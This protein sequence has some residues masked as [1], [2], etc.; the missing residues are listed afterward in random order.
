MAWR[1]F[2][3]TKDSE[4]FFFFFTRDKPPYVTLEAL[5][6][7]SIRLGLPGEAPQPGPSSLPLWVRYPDF[8]LTDLSADDFARLTP[9]GATRKDTA[10]LRVG[11]KEDRILAVRFAKTTQILYNTD[12]VT[13]RV[14]NGPYS[15]QPFLD[16][17][18]AIRGWSDRGSPAG[19]DVE[20]GSSDQGMVVHGILNK[21]IEGY[22]ACRSELAK[23][24]LTSV[25]S[26]EGDIYHIGEYRADLELKLK[27]D[28]SL[29]EKADEERFRLQLRLRVQGLDQPAAELVLAPAGL[30]ISGPLYDSFFDNLTGFDGST[31]L[32]AR[33]GTLI[34]ESSW[35]AR[36]LRAQEFARSA[37]KDS[38]ILLAG[39]GLDAPLYL[40]LMR[41]SLYDAPVTL[42]WVAEFSTKSQAEVSWNLEGQ[43]ETLAGFAGDSGNITIEREAAD[44]IFPIIKNI[45]R[46]GEFL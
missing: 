28:G 13:A 30:L 39:S 22:L 5:V 46:W 1:L 20:V 6:Q 35:Q 32:A 43:M 17:I 8:F 25:V 14:Q 27:D 16:L 4:T 7:T 12:N 42:L 19:S 33:L 24:H 15:L 40:L 18:A 45:K 26:T 36:G 2:V 3:S 38:S 31:F 21:V 29:A 11:E 10:I 34:H 37:R 9:P 41:G 44:F 23:R